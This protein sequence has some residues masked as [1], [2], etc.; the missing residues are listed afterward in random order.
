[1]EKPTLM[2]T[3][4]GMDVPFDLRG[5]RIMRYHRDEPGPVGQFVRE[6]LSAA[7]A[8]PD[9]WIVRPGQPQ[10]ADRV[11]ISYS[12]RDA[13]VLERLLVHL[14]PLER[15]GLIDPWSDR[16][17][18]PGNEWQ[19]E[20]E[21]ALDRARVAILLVTADFLASDFVADNELPPLLE[22]AETSGTII[23]PIIVKPCRYVRDPHLR[24]LQAINDPASPMLSRSEIEQE[25][26]LDDV[27]ARIE[28]AIRRPA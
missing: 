6:H 19:K 3:S 14:R 18:E 20:I 11:F 23:L 7:V 5:S 4:E 27:A 15:E 21:R 16:L 2:I 12:H 13:A 28:K 22:A 1:M 24:R 17:L 9:S 8:D 10:K 25:R 26:L